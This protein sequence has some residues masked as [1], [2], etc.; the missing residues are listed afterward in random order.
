MSHLTRDEL[1]RSAEGTL[2]A[3]QGLHLTACAACREEAEG[4]TSILADVRELKVPEPAPAFWDHLSARVRT[5]IDMEP[6]PRA[7]WWDAWRAPR[8]AWTSAVAAVALA[9]GLYAWWPNANQSADGR[10]GRAATAEPAANPLEAVGQEWDVVMAA[11]DVADWDAT[12]L[13]ALTRP[14]HSDLAVSAL[15]AEE[16]QALVR[17]LHDALAAPKGERREG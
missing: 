17:L 15:T 8:L 10:P 13:E 14:G 3:I 4:L 5:A 7:A 6:A 2:D 11:A 1:L 9:V 16:E 12:E